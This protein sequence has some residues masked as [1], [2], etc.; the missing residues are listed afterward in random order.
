MRY[1]A[2][3]PKPTDTDSRQDR[4]DKAM[5]PTLL[6]LAIAISLGA[7]SAALAVPDF[8]AIATEKTSAIAETK[9][10]IKKWVTKNGNTCFQFGRSVRCW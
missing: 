9:T 5:K 7:T 6:T 2:S 3:D 8:S 4:K 1:I 10:T